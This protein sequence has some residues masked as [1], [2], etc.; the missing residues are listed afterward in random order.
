MSF[1]TERINAIKET[2]YPNDDLCRRIIDAKQYIDT[3]FSENINLDAMAWQ[4]C[5]SKFHFRHLFK[6]LY[7]L[8]PHQYLT[9]VRISRAKQLL[10]CSIPTADVCLA[11]GFESVSS[12]KDLFKRHTSFTPAAWLRYQQKQQIRETVFRFLPYWLHQNR[13]IQDSY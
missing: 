2:L 4:A 1:Y 8:S 6:Q 3:H 11:V 7:G 12:F 13:N 9:S 10:L 5:Y